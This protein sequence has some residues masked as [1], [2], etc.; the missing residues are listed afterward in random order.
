METNVRHKSVE[1][2]AVGRSIHIALDGQ[3]YEGSYTVDGPTLTVHSLTLGV[4][5]SHIGDVAPEVLAKLLLAEMVYRTKSS[6]HN[7]RNGTE[8]EVGSGLLYGQA[9]ER[10]T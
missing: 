1:Q 6:A 8:S 5:V 4:R 3:D 7:V 2:P 10:R 9:H